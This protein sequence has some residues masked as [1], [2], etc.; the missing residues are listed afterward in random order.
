MTH[1]F[2][3]HRA[4]A[5]LMWAPVWLGLLALPGCSWFRSGDESAEPPACS[6]TSLI[7]EA[8]EIPLYPAGIAKPQPS[9]IVATGFIGVYRGACNFKTAGQEEFDLEIDFISKKGPT[10]LA[11]G[12]KLQKIE[13]PYF[14]AVL[15]KDDEILQ[16]QQFSTTVDFDNKDEAASK[17]E[18]LIHIPLPSK[19]AAAGYKIVL[20]F[21]LTPEQLQYVNDHQQD[22]KEA[23]KKDPHAH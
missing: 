18:H 12:K 1:R 11:M 5:P 16:R 9:D 15:S 19:E 7:A 22:K 2:S 10:G 6:D 8:G 3:L 17:E 21:R 13:L 14:L 20:G 4:F 23:D